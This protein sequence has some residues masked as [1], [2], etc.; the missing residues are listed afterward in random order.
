MKHVFNQLNFYVTD[1]IEEFEKTYVTIN[2]MEI[3]DKNYSE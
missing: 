2:K 3:E 1:T